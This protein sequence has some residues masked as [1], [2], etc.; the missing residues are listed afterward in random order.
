[1]KLSAVDAAAVP[2]PASAALLVGG[3]GMLLLSRRR[4]RAA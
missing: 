4:Q 1:M 3:I 2:E